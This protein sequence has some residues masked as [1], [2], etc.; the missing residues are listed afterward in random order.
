MDGSYVS[1]LRRAAGPLRKKG[2]GRPFVDVGA[3]LEIISGVL[4][5]PSPRRLSVLATY[6]G[7]WSAGRGLALG[8][9]GL[10]ELIDRGWRN[11]PVEAPV[12][13]FANPRSGTTLLHR[14]MSFDEQHWVAPLLYET[15]FPSSSLIRSVVSLAE[16]DEKIPGRPLHRFVDGLNAVLVG[17]TWDGIHKLGLDQPEEDEPSF[18]YGMHTPTAMLMVPHV[19]EISSRFWFDE[20]PET[21]RKP[22]MDAYEGVLKRV[23]HAHGGRRR[24][25]N[26]NV[27]FAPRVRSVAERFPDARF[28][29]MVRHPYEAMPS[30]LNMFTSAWRFHS[31]ELANDPVLVRRLAQVGF[32][33]YRAGL[34]LMQDL[35]RERFRVVRYDDLVANPKRTVQSIYGWLDLPI[36]SEFEDK[37]DEALAAQRAYESQHDYS[38]EGFGLTR[39]EVYEELREVF[40]RFGF[41]R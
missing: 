9:Q 19:D 17:D 36:T 15:V 22:F 5:H 16:V 10:D 27:F 35:P 41:E 21:V 7:I 24:F 38:L 23:I 11:Q 29:Y 4:R 37:L 30:F 14:L 32:D 40:D 34:E 3:A 31:P 12:F 28:I 8:F 18:V 13:I 26:K 6:M 1:R 39:D 2:V 20:L 33:Y 25:L